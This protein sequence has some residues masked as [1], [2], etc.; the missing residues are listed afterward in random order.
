MA[1]SP[2]A[3]GQQWPARAMAG[4]ELAGSASLWLGFIG[5]VWLVLRDEGRWAGS[6]LTW[7]WVGAFLIIG[8]LGFVAFS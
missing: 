8:C 2:M 3:A 5:G 1:R 6:A 7:L 4:A